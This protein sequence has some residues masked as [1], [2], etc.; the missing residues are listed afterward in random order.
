MRITQRQQIALVHLIRL[1][2][3]RQYLAIKNALGIAPRTTIPNLTKMEASRL[4]D[5]INIFLKLGGPHR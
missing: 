3:R 1:I 4:L 2:G 5:E